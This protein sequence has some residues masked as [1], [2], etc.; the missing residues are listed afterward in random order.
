MPRPLRIPQII[1]IKNDNPVRGLG[2]GENPF[3]GIVIRVWVSQKEAARTEAVETCLGTFPI[4]IGLSASSILRCLSLTIMYDD[5]VSGGVIS[6][7][8]VFCLNK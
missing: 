4:Y 2:T 3:N 5:G 1:K 7:G 8:W 6:G